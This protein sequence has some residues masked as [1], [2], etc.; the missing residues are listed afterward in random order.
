MALPQL[1]N[2][3]Q[4]S[5]LHTG[6]IEDIGVCLDLH[7]PTAEEIKRFKQKRNG[8]REKLEVGT[9]AKLAIC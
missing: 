2:I 5:E 6:Q 7:F 9:N 4:E 3:Q 8:K 1:I